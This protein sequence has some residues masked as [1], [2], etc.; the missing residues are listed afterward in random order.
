MSPVS[1]DD[2]AGALQH[3]ILTATLRGPVNVT[4]PDAMTNR[5]FTRTLAAVLHR[6]ALVVVP[7]FALHLAMGDMVDELLFA[8][9][10]V[11][12]AALLASGYRFRHPTVESALRHALA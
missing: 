6:P 8:S 12:P 7:R 2:V 4:A 10:R 11:E 9:A 3:C 5:E 1:L